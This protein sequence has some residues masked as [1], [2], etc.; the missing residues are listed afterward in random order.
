M[1]STSLMSRTLLESTNLSWRQISMTSYLDGKR[2]IHFVY[3][4]CCTAILSYARTNYLA[5]PLVLARWLASRV[6]YCISI[7]AMY[8][9][10]SQRV[11]KCSW[12]LLLSLST[13]VTLI[14]DWYSNGT[15]KWGG[16]LHCYT[17]AGLLLVVLQGNI[18]EMTHYWSEPMLKT[19][20]L[21][22]LDV[23]TSL[24]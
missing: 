13:N 17:A 5:G 16:E 21:I 18:L 3:F 10:R 24:R 12:T 15:W 23:F 22:K 14:W 20:V 19:C 1:F 4:K 7:S 2:I 9:W 11:T 6:K 8:S